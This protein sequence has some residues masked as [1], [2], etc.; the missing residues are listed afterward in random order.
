MKAAVGT[1]PAAGEKM[2][3][4]PDRLVIACGERRLDIDRGE[5]TDAPPE[6][7]AD[8]LDAVRARLLH[9]EY[10]DADIDEMRSTRS[11]ILPQECRMK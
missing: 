5:K 9:V 6:P 1:S 10:I 2:R 4:L 8:F 7:F 3:F 11:L